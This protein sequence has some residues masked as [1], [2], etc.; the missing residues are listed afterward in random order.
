V[1]GG[2]APTGDGSPWP[3]SLR[4]E[5]DRCSRRRQGADL[6][7]P[8]KIRQEDEAGAAARS[9]LLRRRFFC[10]LFFSRWS[11]IPTLKP[12]NSSGEVGAPSKAG[13][14]FPFFFSLSVIGD[15]YVEAGRAERWSLSRWSLRSILAVW[16]RESLFLALDFNEDKLLG[17]F[18]WVH[19]ICILSAGTFYWVDRV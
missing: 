18:F 15:T 1:N 2:V 12:G 7:R 10:F 8:M 17:A 11:V 3:C 4:P 16:S 5:R 19:E 9:E 14:L 6:A 13:F